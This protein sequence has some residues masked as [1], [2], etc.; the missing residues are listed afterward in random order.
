LLGSTPAGEAWQ[1]INGWWHA[2]LKG[3]TPPVMVHGVTLGEIRARLS[4]P[5]AAVRQRYLA[6]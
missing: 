2:R 5:A 3:A 4:K 6:G 1:D